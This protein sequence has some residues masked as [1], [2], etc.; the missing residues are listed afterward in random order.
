MLAPAWVV[1]LVEALAAAILIALLVF[2]TTVKLAAA[3]AEWWILAD[4][5]VRAWWRRARRP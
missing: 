2:I 4:R 1:Q 5:A 3:I